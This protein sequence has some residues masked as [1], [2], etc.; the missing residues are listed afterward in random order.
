MLFNINLFTEDEL[1]TILQSA[2]N[3]L[4]EGKSIVQWTSL[5]SS[6]QLQWDIQPMI[7]IQ[8]C[9]K[10]LQRINPGKYGRYIKTGRVQHLEYPI[11]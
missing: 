8:E 3:S 2:K 5:G 11:V 9:T 4:L 7:L 6:A 1:L 10:T